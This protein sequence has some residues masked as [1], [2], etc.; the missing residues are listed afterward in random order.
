[1]LVCYCEEVV[2]THDY[3][4]DT[5]VWLRG[6]ACSGGAW[7]LFGWE[8]RDY[9][10]GDV[11]RGEYLLTFQMEGGGRNEKNSSTR[12]TFNGL[13]Y[14][15]LCKHAFTRHNSDP[16]DGLARSVQEPL[17]LR[18]D[19]NDVYAFRLSDGTGGWVEHDVG[20]RGSLVQFPFLLTDV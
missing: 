16:H 14:L 20:Q 8:N 12:S 7:L 13:D 11:V 2:Q 18:C 6:D 17:L 1:M 15:N 5:W 19:V 3:N 4:V 9:R 10:R